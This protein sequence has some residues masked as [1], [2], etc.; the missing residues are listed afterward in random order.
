[1]IHPAHPAP[2]AIDW[3]AAHQRIATATEAMEELLHPDAERAREILD[4]RARDLAQAGDAPA[5]RATEVEVVTFA[6]ANERY[7]IETRYV[8]EVLKLATITQLPRQLLIGVINLHGDIL[9]VFDLRTLLG[10]PTR[11]ISD[12]FRIMV[13]GQDQPEFGVLADT[14]D[15]VR[16]LSTDTVLALPDSVRSAGR[17]LL[18]G[19]TTDALIML[20]GGLLLADERFRV[21]ETF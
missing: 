21:N 15:E 3:Q 10:A 12:L 11:A 19:V 16:M 5:Q 13:L 20:D 14:V 17:E 2:V 9:A 18:R 4:A 1:M 7:A 6:L 8:L